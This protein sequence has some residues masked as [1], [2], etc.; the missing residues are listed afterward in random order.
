[1]YIHKY[2]NSQSY[3]NKNI[4]KSADMRQFQQSKGTINK[5]LTTTNLMHVI[6]FNYF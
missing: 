3:T 6:I 4:Y 2:R 1:M 5:I